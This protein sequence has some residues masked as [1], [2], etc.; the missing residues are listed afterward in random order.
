[1][2]LFILK[3]YIFPILDAIKSL[4]YIL[5]IMFNT[6]RTLGW[7]ISFITCVYR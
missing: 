5:H 6:Y 1:M 3:I 2:L 4:Y 7:D